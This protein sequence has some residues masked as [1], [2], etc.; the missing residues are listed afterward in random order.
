MSR[1]VERMRQVEG[2]ET[3]ALEES[4][5]RR[6]PAMPKIKEKRNDT[7]M[8]KSITRAPRTV[9][10]HHRLRR[11]VGSAPL[12]GAAR[13]GAGSAADGSIKWMRD[14]SPVGRQAAVAGRRR[15]RER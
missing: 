9:I 2:M 14:P 12:P 6:R 15:W 7:A 8:G 4:P 10:P 5:P 3:D 11:S 13:G 1:P